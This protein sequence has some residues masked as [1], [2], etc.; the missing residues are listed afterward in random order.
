MNLKCSH[1]KSELKKFSKEDKAKYKRNPSDFYSVIRKFKEIPD[2]LEKV[3][4]AIGLTN[5]DPVSKEQRPVKQIIEHLNR[6]FRYSYAV[7]NGFNLL[8]YKPPVEL[9]VLKK[10]HNMPNKWNILLDEA[11]ND[12]IKSTMEF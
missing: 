3:T 9:D 2:I 6:T 4:Q 10:T 11:L 5:D 12:Y 1:Y 7:K 8:E